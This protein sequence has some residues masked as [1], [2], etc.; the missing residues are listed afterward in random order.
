M[1]GRA[2][3]G[4]S[5]ASTWRSLQKDL[6]LQAY[7]I[8]L[9]QELKPPDLPKRRVFS[10]WA[11]ENHN[12]DPL[13]HR[14]IL[15]SDEAHFW[16]NGYVNKRNCRIWGDAQQEMIRKQPLH[17]A[18][19]TVWCSLWAGGIIGSYFVT[20]QAGRNVTVNGSRYR[21]MLTDSPLPELQARDVSDI[22]FQ[23]V[24]LLPILRMKP[25][26]H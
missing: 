24:G 20:Y 4:L 16:L 25:L 6:G 1:W 18:K 12:E 2:V 10:A 14:R 13:F 22:W 7:K 8:Q 17:P 3:V 15:F 9:V 11:L 21:S 23:Q 26:I 5:Y 19:C